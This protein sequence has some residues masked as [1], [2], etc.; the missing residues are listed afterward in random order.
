MTPPALTGE[1]APAVTL[2]G[3]TLTLR[4]AT[5]AAYRDRALADHAR[6]ESMPARI[7]ASQVDEVPVHGLGAGSGEVVAAYV[8]APIEAPAAKPTAAKR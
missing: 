6:V 1:G 8:L 3:A 4:Y 2:N 5:F 7:V